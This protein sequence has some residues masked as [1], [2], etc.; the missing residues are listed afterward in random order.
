MNDYYELFLVVEYFENKLY[1]IVC[2]KLFS[3]EDKVMYFFLRK[4]GNKN[5]FEEFIND[6]NEICGRLSIYFFWFYFC[7][8]GLYEENN[9]VYLE[10]FM[11][12]QKLLFGCWQKVRVIN[13]LFYIYLGG[14][15]LFFGN[16]VG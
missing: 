3:V 12:F 9:I 8:F 13:S 1:L 16:D 14:K 11:L 6:M 7:C 5:I 4:K 10:Q 15:D 2:Y